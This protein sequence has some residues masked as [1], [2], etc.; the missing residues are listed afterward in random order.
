MNKPNSEVLKRLHEN[1]STI[2]F[3]DEFG[4]AKQYAESMHKNSF[5][6]YQTRALD[7]GLTGQ[8]M[9]DAGCGTG[10]WSFAWATQFEKVI[11]IDINQPRINLANWLKEKLEIGNVFFQSGDVT[12]LDFPTEEF[13]TI[14]CYSVVISYLPIEVI[15][16]EFFRVLKPGGNLFV[17]LNGNGW[18]I[19]L[20]DVRSQEG[21]KYRLMGEQG[22]YNTICQRDLSVAR[23]RLIQI[24]EKVKVKHSVAEFFQQQVDVKMERVEEFFQSMSQV[25]KFVDSEIVSLFP[26]TKNHQDTQESTGIL[27]R[28]IDYVSNIEK[29][30]DATGI[31]SNLTKAMQEIMKECGEDYIVQ[32][33]DDIVQILKGHKNQFSYAN[34]SRGYEPDEVKAICEQ[35]GF[36]NFRWAKKNGILSNESPSIN[37]DSEEDGKESKKYLK[38]WEFLVTKVY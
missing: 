16:R 20:R 4:D 24:G 2:Q 17:N 25:K 26:T 29:L 18:S 1:W 27:S 5:N 30:L 7:L 14:F 22:L 38:T 13:D 11:G 23:N 10:T 31:Q 15:L 19:Y 33:A 12:N 28:A 35:I 36:E 9:L 21:E 34:K 3:A 32:L 6:H 37:T 8:L